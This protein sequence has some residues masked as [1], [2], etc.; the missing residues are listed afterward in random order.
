QRALEQAARLAGRNS[1]AAL[2][3]EPTVTF[4]ARLQNEAGQFGVSVVPG[5]LGL[6]DAQIAVVGQQSEAVYQGFAAQVSNLALADRLHGDQ[7]VEVRRAGEALEVVHHASYEGQP[8]DAVARIEA[9]DGVLR[10]AWSMPGVQRDSRGHPRYS[11]LH[12]GPS[13]VA[14]KRIYF[15]HGHVVTGVPKMSMGYGGFAVTTRYI[16]VDYENGL[17]LVQ[18]AD[19]VPDRLEH[20]QA[21]GLTSLVAHHD[22]TFT[23]V[24]S[25]RGAF[26]AARVWRGQSGLQ[27][28]PGVAAIR[29][30][31]CIDQWGGDYAEAAAGLKLA[32][33]Y[34][35][36]EAVFVKH[37]W[38]R[39]GYDYRLPDIYPPAGD[40]AAF[41]AMVAA[42]KANG[43]LF[44]LHD[45]YIDIYPDATDFTFD[46]VSFNE[47]GTPRR[48]WFNEGR[49]AQSYKWDPKRFLPF[50]EANL[51]IIEREIDPSA[52]FIDVWSAA[53]PVD[54]YGR[55][56]D[57]R[58]K[59][60]D[61][62][63][64][65]QGFDRT[66]ELLGGPTISEAGHDALIGHLDAAQADHLTATREGGRHVMRVDFQDW[67]RTP[68][69]D[70]GHHGR[71]VLFAGG[72]GGR[73]QAEQPTKLAGYGSDDYLTNTVLGGRTPMC[74]GPFYR[75]TVMTY[76]LLQPL[77]AELERQEMLAHQ[78]AGDNIHRQ[79]V[80]WSAGKVSVNRGADDWA[81]E[82]VTLP[83]FG[84]VAQAADHRAEISRRDGVIAAMAQS[85]GLLFVDARPPDDYGSRL[86]EVTVEVRG[87]KDLG[88]RRF[89]VDQVWDI[90]APLPATVR[91]FV[92]VTGPLALLPG[93][94][95]NSD[96]LFQAGIGLTPAMLA[97][98]GRYEVTITGT[99][100]E[101]LLPGELGL[102]Y[103]LYDPARGG[104]RL[105]FNAIPTDGDRFSAGTV[106][107]AGSGAETKLTWTAPEPRPTGLERD[108]VARKVVDF[109]AVRTNGA[110]RCQTR[111]E[112]LELTLL[113]GSKAAEVELRLALLGVKGRQ[114]ARFEQIGLDGRATPLTAVARDGVVSFTTAPGAFRYRLTLR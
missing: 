84:F 35:L 52:Y 14:T 101:Q 48:A 64:S 78:F 5:P 3:P 103:G 94:T 41:D 47:D 102:K 43:R 98:P 57:F 22:A 17:A 54:H 15:G 24:P 12:L 100:P 114:V 80:T 87:F 83:P 1:P 92:H 111:G 91:P 30:K 95:P 2:V 65:A 99:L 69:F 46:L 76:W 56:G 10:I 105:L 113:P 58:P 33:A 63:A 104:P 73:Y 20:D 40:R 25:E 42:A 32:T 23:L 112:T 86:E 29:G 44:A 90:R 4:G 79:Q 81:V 11:L 109:G 77:C 36:D 93:V 6:L 71:F 8:F 59:M 70:M 97:T 45:N 9:R 26:A 51:K 16:G 53:P 21:A 72:L 49:Q 27:A 62:A 85:P 88:Q 107:V 60:V 18:A 38:Q 13:A 55:A 82:G 28:A 37:V 34:G 19:P 7:P 106:T 89:Q 96:I 110:L 61:Q 74:D 66:R 68:W 50:L 75:R 108:N 39:W 31:M 67:D